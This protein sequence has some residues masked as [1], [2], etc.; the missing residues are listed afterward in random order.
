M[1]A[2]NADLDDGSSWSRDAAPARTSVGAAPFL[3]KSAR[4]MVRSQA[5]S[6]WRFYH[7]SIRIRYRMYPGGKMRAACFCLLLLCGSLNAA[8]TVR[9]LFEQ[10]AG[11][12]QKGDLAGAVR[13]YQELLKLQPGMVAARINLGVALA[14]LGRYDE[15]IATY[16]EALKAEPGNVPARMNLGLAYYKSTQY[17]PAAAEFTRLRSVRPDLPQPFYLL[18]NCYLELGENRRVI[19]LLESPAPPGCTEPGCLYVL[20]LALMRDGQTGR[21]AA[22]LD[23]LQARGDSLE[24]TLLAGAA[25]I[26]TG[27]YVEAVPDLE[28]AIRHSPQTAGL[29]SLLGVAKAGMHDHEGAKPLFRKALELDPN[30]FDS[31]LNLG[32]LLL[33]DRDIDG[34]EPLLRRA[35]RIRTASSA[36]RFQIGVL[37]Q[38][39]GQMQAAVESFESLARDIPDWIDPHLQL[40]KLYYSLARP[41]DGERERAV[42]ERLNAASQQR[43]LQQLPTSADKPPALPQ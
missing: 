30:D 22:V 4:A 15:A 29:Y 36:A 34:A 10:A 7:R 19:E 43:I 39:R 32:A 9:E 18:A 5:Q 21:G 20:G 40:L 24:A 25:K 2:A 37:Q 12:Q 33:Q 23:R 17:A 3:M 27:Q 28:Q 31:N 16:R 1:G 38:A 13:L 42:I 35:Q 6:H 14:G 26:L 11:L 8:D 41:A